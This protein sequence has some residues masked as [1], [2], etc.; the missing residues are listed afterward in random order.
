MYAANLYFSSVQFARSARP[1][2]RLRSRRPRPK[3]VSFLM[4]TTFAPACHETGITRAGRA[5]DERRHAAK[6]RR[7][8]RRVH[9][10]RLCS[11]QSAVCSLHHVL[12]ASRLPAD[13]LKTD[14]PRPLPLFPRLSTRPSPSLR[15]SGPQALTGWPQGTTQGHMR[16]ASASAPAPR[17]QLL[18]P[19]CDPV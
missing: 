16:A 6:I 5:R 11:L 19:S 3:S 10:H 14:G 7:T 2:T 8:V 18:L 13:G 12:H 1:G 9:C 17:H 15:P 4:R